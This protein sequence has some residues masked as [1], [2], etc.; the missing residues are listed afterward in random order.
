MISI[1][2]TC[3]YSRDSFESIYLKKAVNRLQEKDKTIEV[4]S[5]ID[6]IKMN[7]SP[8]IKIFLVGTKSDLEEDRQVQFSEG[9]MLKN[10]YNLDEFMEVSAQEGTNTKELFLKAVLLLL[11]KY[12][13]LKGNFNIPNSRTISDV[14]SLKKE[15]KNK[16]KSCSC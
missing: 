2:L 7:S 14:H 16:K 10:K 8:D 4:D 15:V 13:N 3:F 5:W 1:K 11:S 9:E 6:E 12:Q